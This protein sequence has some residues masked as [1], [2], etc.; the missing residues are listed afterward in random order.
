MAYEESWHYIT[1]CSSVAQL[2]EYGTQA[3]TQDKIKALVIPDT[4][5]AVFLGSNEAILYSE[6]NTLVIQRN[7]KMQFYHEFGN[8][9][10]HMKA[11]ELNKTK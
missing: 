10:Q 2:D 11:V 1:F 6:E 7:N 8:W 4:M 3:V 9:I 5:S